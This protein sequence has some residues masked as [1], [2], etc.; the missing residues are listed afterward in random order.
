MKIPDNALL[1]CLPAD[2]VNGM[3]GVFDLLIRTDAKNEITAEAGRLKKKILQHGRT[4]QSQDE[5]SVSILFF[6]TE[7]RSLLRIL[8]LYAFAVQQTCRDYYPEIG[9]V[10][11]A[12]SDTK[13]DASA[14]AEN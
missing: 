2:H 7:L 4:F 9:R 3:L 6:E 5:D 14:S 10:K 12:R 13:R 8:T 1:I 11:K